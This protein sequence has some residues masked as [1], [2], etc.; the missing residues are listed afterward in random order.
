MFK[1]YSD[2]TSVLPKEIAQQGRVCPVEHIL[3]AHAV[4]DVFAEALS[5][6]LGQKESVGVPLTICHQ[7]QHP[8]K[9][10]VCWTTSRFLEA[11]II[12][13]VCFVVK[14]QTG[15]PTQDFP[16][17]SEHFLLFNHVVSHLLDV[18]GGR[19]LIKAACAVP[20]HCT[21]LLRIWEWLYC[22]YILVVLQIILKKKNLDLKVPVYCRLSSICGSPNSSCSTFF[23]TS[24]K[25]AAKPMTW[26]IIVIYYSYL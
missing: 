12:T 21:H 8:H 10:C 4:W 17:E 20:P 23:R 2:L 18:S 11:H 25:K 6:V 16:Y 19:W 22:C 13:A 7:K 14:Y 5:Y 24:E 9:A 26:G 3:N 1:S 15:F